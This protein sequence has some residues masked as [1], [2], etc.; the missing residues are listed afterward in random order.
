MS[1]GT[2][3]AGKRTAPN[4]NVWLDDIRPAPDGWLWAKTVREA[5]RLLHSS[6][7]TCEVEDMSLDNDLG[8]NEPEGRHLVL[9]MCEHNIWPKGKIAVHSSNPVAAEYMRKM[10]E[11]YGPNGIF[12]RYYHD[13]R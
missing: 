12:Y 5:K 3:S 1:L 13:N 8:L 4:M 9:W 10:I 11:R 6:E 7:P 2:K